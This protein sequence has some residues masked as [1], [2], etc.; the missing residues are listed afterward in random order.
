MVSSFVLPGCCPLTNSESVEE[1]PD[2]FFFP[3]DRMLPTL[4]YV[5]NRL[6]VDADGDLKWF[7][8]APVNDKGIGALVCA[9]SS[10]H[11][12]TQD[13][14]IPGR[15]IFPPNKAEIELVVQTTIS[16]PSIASA[17]LPV[18]MSRAETF[19]DHSSTKRR[20]DSGVGLKIFTC[21]KSRIISANA[22]WSQ[23]GLKIQVEPRLVPSVSNW[24]TRLGCCC[25][26]PPR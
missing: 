4:G 25:K 18:S 9:A 3:R 6:P 8:F 2:S 5:G 12:L 21:V 13:T 11:G 15:R 20:R 16:A 19:P 7:G 1:I 10:S 22:Q 24:V 23:S 17:T 14:C 26:I